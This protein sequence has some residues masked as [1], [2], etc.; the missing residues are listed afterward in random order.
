MDG[1]NWSRSSGVTPGSPAGQ[2][3]GPAQAVEQR[4]GSI[5]ELA[6][7]IRP[8]LA[9]QERAGLVQLR[10]TVHAERA[11][12]GAAQ[13]LLA[14]Q[15]GRRAPEDVFGTPA[16]R[17]SPSGHVRVLSPDE[18]RADPV[19]ALLNR[20]AAERIDIVNLASVRTREGFPAE[21][22]DTEPLSLAQEYTGDDLASAIALR[23]TVDQRVLQ[24]QAGLL[25]SLERALDSTLGEEAGAAG[26]PPLQLYEPDRSLELHA[27]Q[28][29]AVTPMRQGADTYVGY[30]R[31]RA[32]AEVQAGNATRRPAIVEA[33]R[34][35]GA[36]TLAPILA[37]ER[38][39]LEALRRGAFAYG[40]GELEAT[41]RMPLE[42]RR[43]AELKLNSLLQEMVETACLVQNVLDRY[44]GTDGAPGNVQAGT[45]LNVAGGELIA[46]GPDVLARQAL[47]RVA[48]A[49][50][51]LAEIL[52]HTALAA[53]LAVPGVQPWVA[54]DLE[55]TA[56]YFAPVAQILAV[57]RLQMWPQ[58]SDAADVSA[59][60]REV[61][62][63][64][65]PGTPE[66][67][68]ALSYYDDI[69]A[70]IA[71]ATQSLSKLRADL[72]GG[73]MGPDEVAVLSAIDQVLE[74]Q[75]WPADPDE[76][77]QASAHAQRLR[78]LTDRIRGYAPFQA[79][80]AGL[81]PALRALDGLFAGD[82]AKR[83]YLADLPI[84][85]RSAQER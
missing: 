83:L 22:V 65:Q 50:E 24:A 10:D 3:G 68:L 49:D 67:E 60:L 41:R 6:A 42:E 38:S 53:E 35:I 63:A 32:R 26:V 37:A 62:P 15:L 20:M 44:P 30:Q 74:Q 85:M 5:T 27:L 77:S 80:E 64:Q 71:M 56:T 51:L 16:D 45:M 19:S 39:A 73:T 28:L 58:V 81:G 7:E 55:Q 84:W 61:P 21:P 78:D 8:W 75:H 34:T 79:D 17:T 59:A 66:W 29:A 33:M 57:V 2:P 13:R 76:A 52:G 47:A 18:E 69:D 23:G 12:V 70:E 54:Y 82:A 31:Q 36:D 14:A 48:C 72:V 43:E 9:R 46:D 1:V 25:A 4:A 11:A 40:A